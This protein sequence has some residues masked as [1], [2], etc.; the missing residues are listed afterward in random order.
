MQKS[1]GQLLV[2]MIK[3]VQRAS[4]LTSKNR[5]ISDVS[6]PGYHI[7]LDYI[8]TSSVRKKIAK[9]TSETTLYIQN[10]FFFLQF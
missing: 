2:R 7:N 1:V 5:N 3:I 10:N 8:I 4:W 6:S 9:F